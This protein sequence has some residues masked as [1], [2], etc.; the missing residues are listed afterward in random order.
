MKRLLSVAA[1]SAVLLFPAVPARAQYPSSEISAIYRNG[2]REM[3]DISERNQ[4][5]FVNFC[6]SMPPIQPTPGNLRQAG[7]IAES[8][9]PNPVLGAQIRQVFENE[10]AQRRVPAVAP[11]FSPS[12]SRP[13][14]DAQLQQLQQLY[15]ILLFYRWLQEQERQER[16]D[17]EIE[18]RTPKYAAAH[19]LPLVSA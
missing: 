9:A 17:R 3:R 16:I 8:L 5:Q 14:P 15:M 6:N 4:R 11:A 19:F 10:A 7:A 1:L 2:L 12:R 18:R 13:R